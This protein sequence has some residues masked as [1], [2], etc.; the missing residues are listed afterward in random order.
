MDMTVGGPGDEATIVG[1]RFERERVV[2]G[3]RRFE[4]CTFESCELVVDGRPVHLVDNSLGRSRWSFEGPA[5]VTLDL[6]AL[7]CREDP[8]LAAMIGGALGLLGETA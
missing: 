8:R 2:L 6:V 5:A 3:G 4:R 1:R 7:L